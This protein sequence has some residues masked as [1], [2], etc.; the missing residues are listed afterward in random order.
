[1]VKLKDPET[2][3]GGTGELRFRV[4]SSLYPL[5]CPFPPKVL[6]TH[7]PRML[8]RA[9]VSLFMRHLCEPGA[10]GSETFADGVPR[11]GAESPASVDPHWSHVSRQERYWSSLTQRVRSGGAA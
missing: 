4:Q 6:L 8:L 1:M 2:S 7:L 11:E 9:Y 5:H 3:P 10:D